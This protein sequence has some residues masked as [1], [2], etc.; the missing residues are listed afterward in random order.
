MDFDLRSVCPHTRMTVTLTV[1]EQPGQ[2]QLRLTER[3]ASE[4]TWVKFLL[5]S[6]TRMLLPTIEFALEIKSYSP[7]DVTKSKT[8]K[9]PGRERRSPFIF[10]L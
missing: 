2:R 6:P 1:S 3:E 7:V 9:P 8:A 5:M 4:M 10:V